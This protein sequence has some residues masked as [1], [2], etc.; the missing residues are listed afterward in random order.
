MGLYSKLF[1]MK[2]ALKVIRKDLDETMNINNN[3]A[4]IEDHIEMK[5]EN[6]H[7]S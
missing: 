3:K 4:G 2:E 6:N 5:E 7:L 1:E